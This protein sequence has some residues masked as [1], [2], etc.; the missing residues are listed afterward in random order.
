[1]SNSP[2]KKTKY[3]LSIETPIEVPLGDLD[4]FKNISQ[5]FVLLSRHLDLEASKIK[6]RQSRIDAEAQSSRKKEPPLR[7]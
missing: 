4:L 2:S 7:S 6:L 5:V 3:N 1:M